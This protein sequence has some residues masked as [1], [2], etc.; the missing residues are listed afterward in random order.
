MS[1]HDEAWLAQWHLT[2]LE[3]DRLDFDLDGWAEIPVKTFSAAVPPVE[4]ELT[5]EDRRVAA[6]IRERM[7]Y[8]RGLQETA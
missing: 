2:Q 4:G 1:T 6:G 8:R 7:R 5:E 3:R